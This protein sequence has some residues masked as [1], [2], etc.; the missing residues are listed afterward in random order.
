MNQAEHLL[1]TLE[2]DKRTAQNYIHTL[3]KANDYD[4]TKRMPDSAIH[5]LYRNTQQVMTA[6]K[7][8][9]ELDS[10]GMWAQTFSSM[11]GN[12]ANCWLNRKVPVGYNFLNIT[13]DGTMHEKQMANNLHWLATH[14]Y[15]DQKIIVWSVNQH[16]T[17][18]NDLLQVDIS[19]Y[20]KT[21]N[22]TMGHELYKLMQDDIFIMGFTSANG[23]TG[24]PYQRTGQPFN[25]GSMGRTDWYTNSLSA[26]Q[27]HYAFTDFRSIRKHPAGESTFTMRGWGY[28]YAMKGQ[29]FNVFDGMF[30]IK[31]N[32]AA[33]ASAEYYYEDEEEEEVVTK[34]KKR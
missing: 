33:T 19:T 17:K 34:A 21:N 7:N 11:M 25:I 32:R 28:E 6:L 31:T 23:T 18:N 1:E 4:S 13:M 2:Y 30:F 9:A 26:A 3:M 27:L 22:T 5:F 16:I 24:S 12:A 20:R 10:N 14:K 8:R 29:W 15:K